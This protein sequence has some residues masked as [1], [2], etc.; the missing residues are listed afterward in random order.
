MLVLL[1][2]ATVAAAP[3]D[4]LRTPNFYRV[5]AGCA[6]A[7]ERV[8]DRFG[9]PMPLRLSDLPGASAILL[10]DRKVDGCPVITVMRGSVPAAPDRP[11]PPPSAYRLHPLDKA[12]R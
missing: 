1:A 4:V 11:N 10:V 2:A 7:R 5:P 3:P 12:P 8:V 6:D 9:R